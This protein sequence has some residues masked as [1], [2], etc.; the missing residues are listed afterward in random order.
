MMRPFDKRTKD[1][2]WSPVVDVP[3]SSGTLA[4]KAELP[5]LK[6]EE[7]RVEVEGDNLVIAGDRRRE[8]KDETEETY[9]LARSYGHFWKSLPLPAGSKADGVK[10]QLTDG[11]FTVTVP[12]LEI[13]TDVK[14]IPVE[15]GNTLKAAAA[16]KSG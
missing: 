4:V 15:K 14:T 1:E 3:R 9:R 7:V 10:A 2:F 13:K 6:R 11:V 8:E 5:G 16:Q 12:I